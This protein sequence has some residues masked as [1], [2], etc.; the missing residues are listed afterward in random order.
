MFFFSRI[1]KA[2]S[3]FIS[4]NNKNVRVLL[5]NQSDMFDIQKQEF[6]IFHFEISRN[7]TNTK[8]LQY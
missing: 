8:R 3:K 2:F 6:P 5:K 1:F 7:P 4:A